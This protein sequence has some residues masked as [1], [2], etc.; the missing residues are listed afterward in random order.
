MVSMLKNSFY[1]F[2]RWLD[3]N[4]IEVSLLYKRDQKL[5]DL[6]I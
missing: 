4:N 2:N 5:N 1:R 3:N 6:G